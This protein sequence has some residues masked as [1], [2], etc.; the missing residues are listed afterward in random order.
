M[1]TQIT[2]QEINLPEYEG[3]LQDDPFTAEERPQPEDATYHNS[4]I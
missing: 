2:A 4:K 1:N 3:F